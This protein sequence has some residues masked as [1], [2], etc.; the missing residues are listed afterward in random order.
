MAKF[1]A[2][3]ADLNKDGQL[4]AYEKNRGESTAAAMPMAK[5]YAMQM[6]SKEIDSPSTFPM[7]QA[8]TIRM[9]PMLQTENEEGLPQDI[10]SKTIAMPSGALA[11]QTDVTS[12]LKFQG[13]PQLLLPSRKVLMLKFF[14][15]LKK[16]KRVNQ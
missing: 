4:S 14:Q 3:K 2:K 16:M 1:D 15:V 5:G 7:K 12:S 10:D 8:H 11:T 13:Q 6:G 9:S